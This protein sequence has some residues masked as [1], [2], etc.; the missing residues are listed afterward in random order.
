MRI[1]KIRGRRPGWRIVSLICIITT[2]VLTFVPTT[3]TENSRSTEERIMRILCFGDSLT[4]GVTGQVNLKSH[5][6][7]FHPYSMK[8]QTYFDFHDHT[9]MGHFRPIVEVHNAGTSGETAHDQMLLKLARILQGASLKYSWVVI[10]AGADDLHTVGTDVTKRGYPNEIVNSLVRLHDV[11]LENGAKTVAVTITDGPCELNGDCDKFWASRND[12][13]EA[14]RNFAELK[15]PGRVVVA[16]VAKNV[17]FFHE[18]ALWSG[19]RYYFSPKGYDRIAT[20]IYSAM[21]KHF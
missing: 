1:L 21:K 3:P 2:V 7:I 15:S 4:E 10:F 16:D 12:I 9:I 6:P 11:S 13:N 14:L 8:L 19:Q 18:E 5:H 20:V 17:S